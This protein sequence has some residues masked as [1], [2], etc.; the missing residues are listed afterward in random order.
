MQGGCFFVTSRI[1]IVDLLDGKVDPSIVAGLL[2]ANAHRYCISNTLFYFPILILSEI[3]PSFLVTFILI[4]LYY[5]M[6]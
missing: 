5:M 4:N 2:I 3:L 1:F 6:A